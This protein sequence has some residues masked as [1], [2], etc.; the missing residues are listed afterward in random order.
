MIR[1]LF[2]HQD[3]NRRGTQP[4]MLYVKNC[5][6]KILDKLS[7]I[8]DTE[9]QSNIFFLHSEVITDQTEQN[10]KIILTGVQKNQYINIK[11]KYH[12]GVVTAIKASLNRKYNSDDRSWVVSPEDIPALITRLEK[13]NS[14]V[15]YTSLLQ[16]LPRP[17]EVQEIV[18]QSMPNQTREPFTHQLDAAKFLLQKKT[19]I[20]F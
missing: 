10:Q 19:V 18:L 14:E 8:A 12:A 3:N 5:S 16:F 11:C 17:E 9:K 20:I 13:F 6:N 15:D 4:K 7:Q 1:I 2:N